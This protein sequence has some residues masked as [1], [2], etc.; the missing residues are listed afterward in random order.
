[1]FHYQKKRLGFHEDK[2]IDNINRKSSE[3]YFVY[4]KTTNISVRFLKRMNIEKEIHKNF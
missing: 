2:I 1:M 3:N 4:F